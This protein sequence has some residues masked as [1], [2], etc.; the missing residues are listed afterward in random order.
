[1]TTTNRPNIAMMTPAERRAFFSA[2]TPEVIMNA[3]PARR[4]PPKPRRH[5][6]R[7]RAYR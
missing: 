3:T 4:L 2:A 6:V 5:S 7:H 1:M